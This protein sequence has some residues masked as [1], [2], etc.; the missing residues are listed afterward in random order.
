MYGL[1]IPLYY[2]I[3]LTFTFYVYK[4]LG[5]FYEFHGVLAIIAES[6]ER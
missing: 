5:L 3:I 6:C 4:H 1:Y 2:D